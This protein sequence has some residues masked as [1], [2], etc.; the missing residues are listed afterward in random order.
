MQPANFQGWDNLLYPGT[1]P[2]LTVKR[3]KMR[4][5]AKPLICFWFSYVVSLSS[6]WKKDCIINIMYTCNIIVHYIIEL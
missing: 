1:K 2:H 6:A 3:W 4:W 5:K